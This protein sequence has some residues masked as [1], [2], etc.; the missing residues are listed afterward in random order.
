MRKLVGIG[1]GPGAED[2]ITLRALRY[3]ERANH[4]FVPRNRGKT[5]AYDIV[6]DFIDEDK[7]V[8]LDFPMG[9]ELKKKYEDTARLIDE[10]TK[11]GELSVLITLGDGTI[12]TTLLEVFH[13]D[14]LN[15][16]RMELVPG[17]PAFLAGINGI[18]EGLVKKGDSFLLMDSLKD[19][20]ELTVD[21]VAILKTMRSEDTFH[22]LKAAGYYSLY[23]ENIETDNWVMTDDPEKCRDRKAYM[24]L[25]LARREPWNMAAILNR[26]GERIKVL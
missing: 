25:I 10:T 14:P 3:L 12:Y 11:D 23:L 17:I 21:T 24:S 22:R 1:V 9:E 5:R 15:D 7:L 6:K 19:E 13:R 18:V 26:I 16:I 20:E 2:L 8:F 4:I